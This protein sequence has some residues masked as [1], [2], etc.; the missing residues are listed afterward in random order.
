MQH[1]PLIEFETETAIENAFNLNN[2]CKTMLSFVRSNLI[3]PN[4]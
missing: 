4:Q 2:A 3:A 1:T